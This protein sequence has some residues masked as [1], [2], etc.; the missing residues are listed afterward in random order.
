[1]RTEW[2]HAKSLQEACRRALPEARG[3]DGPSLECRNVQLLDAEECL[4]GGLD[5][6]KEAN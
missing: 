3:C 5:P 4:V 1:M 2:V 6:L